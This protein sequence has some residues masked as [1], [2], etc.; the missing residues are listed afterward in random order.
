MHA[1]R[2]L[3]TLLL[4]PL[5]SLGAPTETPSAIESEVDSEWAVAT[6][7]VGPNAV[8]ARA[9]PIIVIARLISLIDMVFDLVGSLEDD[10][11]REVAF[12]RDTINALRAEYPAYNVLVYHDEPGREKSTRLYPVS[13][14][15]TWVCQHAE[16]DRTFGTKG[17]EVCLVIAGRFVQGKNQDGGFRNWGWRSRA[18]GGCVDR[19]GGG[20]Q[21]DFCEI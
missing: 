7:E 8:E 19:P 9:A 17:Y 11:E 13:V 1:F 10:E 16:R 21:L 12:I 20:K 6:V 5:T 14:G 3:L 15:N 18:Q 4:L 2:A